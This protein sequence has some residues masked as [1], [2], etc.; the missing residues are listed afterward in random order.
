MYEMRA[1]CRSLKTSQPVHTLQFHG[2]LVTKENLGKGSRQG[3]EDMT[4]DEDGE[5]ELMELLTTP[6]A[7]QAMRKHLV[8]KKA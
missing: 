8:T 3:D 6:N 1:G 2:K 4:M 5:S 7:P